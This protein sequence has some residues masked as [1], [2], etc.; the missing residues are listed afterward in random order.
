M[1]H[2]RRPRFRMTIHKGNHVKPSTMAA[3]GEPE[4]QKSD[5]VV[6]HR[7]PG[8]SSIAELMKQYSK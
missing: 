4:K 5:P 2:N 7:R 3:G 6:E 8:G 1:H